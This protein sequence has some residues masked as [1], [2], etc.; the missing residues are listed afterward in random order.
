MV[1]IETKRLILREFEPSDR[2]DLKAVLADP[3]VM[4][5]YPQPLDWAATDA[6][7]ARN[8]R[9]YGET[10]FGLW[11]LIIKQ[12]GQLVGDCGLVKQQVEGKGVVEL[13]YHI[14]RDWWGQGLAT[15]AALA[16]RNWGLYEQDL[17]SLVSI[18]HPDNRASQRVAEKVGMRRIA[19]TQWQQ[20]RVWLYGIER[21]APA[22]R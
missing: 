6:W 10:G 17:T 19:I 8:R 11:A 21:P 15:E 14:R 22:T 20:Q 9:R 5:F 16:C 13:G 2:D 3:E 7:I 4:R 18:I 12:T 1:V